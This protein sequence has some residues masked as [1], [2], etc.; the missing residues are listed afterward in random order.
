MRPTLKTLVKEVLKRFGFGILTYKYLQQLEAKSKTADNI[1][2]LLE[3]P[4][5]HSVQLLSVLSHSK[6]Q[7]GQDLFVLSELNFK[8]NGF[9]VEFGATDGLDCSNTYLL[10]TEFGWSGILAEPA[11]CWHKNLR[12]NRTCRI[13]TDCV[14]RESNSTLTFNEVDFR[15]LS[16]IDSFDSTDNHRQERRHGR[17]YAVKTI[18]LEDLLDKYNAPREIDYISI[19]T[20]GSEYEILC[21]FDFEKYHFKL[22]T[23]EHN[24]TPQREKI[25]SLLTGHGYVRK[26]ETT[27]QCDDWYV[28]AR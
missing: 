12:N 28:R 4:R 23:C 6:S 10:E 1:G 13:D 7:L 15:E 16:T 14:W 26:F 5:H 19:D 8:R 24:F 20:E 17:T 27:S 9:F 3:L 21:N 18:S 25:F 2:V 22:I 11:R